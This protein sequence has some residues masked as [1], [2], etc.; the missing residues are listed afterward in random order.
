MYILNLVLGCWLDNSGSNGAPSSEYCVDHTLS[1]TIDYWNTWPNAWPGIHYPARVEHFE[2]YEYL[3]VENI[4]LKLTVG[5]CYNDE[6]KV[7]KT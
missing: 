5:G 3:P 1:Q 2:V 4:E 7:S 6:T